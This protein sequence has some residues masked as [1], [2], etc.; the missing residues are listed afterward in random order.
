MESCCSDMDSEKSDD[1]ISEHD[2]N[3][4]INGNTSEVED[5]VESSLSNF[6]NDSDNRPNS[7]QDVKYFCRKNKYGWPSEPAI[8]RG[9]TLNSNIVVH[10][11]SLKGP[12]R[13]TQELA[14][15]EV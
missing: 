3:S 10:L 8:A 2:R 12:L 5:E 15:K 4:V 11:P 1:E 7:N 6:E 9:R 14:P 13:H